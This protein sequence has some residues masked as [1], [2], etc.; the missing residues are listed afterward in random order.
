MAH[1]A[2]GGS[3]KHTALT[4][5]E[6]FHGQ[7]PGAA[8]LQGSAYLV[9]IDTMRRWLVERFL[10]ELAL[11]SQEQGRSLRTCASLSQ[12][13]AQASGQP[14]D[15]ACSLRDSRLSAPD[16]AS[17][18]T[19]PAPSARLRA[20]PQPP[21][22][23][24]SPLLPS[25]AA[26]HAATA[27]N[28]ANGWHRQHPQAAF[29]SLRSLS[30]SAAPCCASVEGDGDSSLPPELEAEL[31]GAQDG[32]PESFALDQYDTQG[33]DSDDHVWTQI[34]GTGEDTGPPAGSFRR[35]Y[36]DLCEAAAAV[37]PPPRPARKRRA[38]KKTPDAGNT[39]GDDSVPTK[40][41][42]RKAVSPS[43]VFKTLR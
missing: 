25:I 4:L 19:T 36:L 14:S 18:L 24:P 39:E 22:A 21:R 17:E 6:R 11:R 33:L 27:L 29:R 30:V 15:A 41:P 12:T 7:G 2:H 35:A 20:H 42:P 28:S 26:Q 38:V 40:G 13:L 31:E 43:S 1:G 5:K 9:A 34:A 32:E 8:C 37:P 16:E 10:R 3:A 23:S